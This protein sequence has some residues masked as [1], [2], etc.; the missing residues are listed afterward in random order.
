M[1]EILMP[2]RLLE[3][4]CLLS[5]L[6]HDQG[7]HIDISALFEISFIGIGNGPIK[8][9]LSV[10]G[11]GQISALNIG[12]ISIIFPRYIGKT[13][14]YR[15]FIEYRLSVSVRLRTDK[16]SVIGDRL[17]SNIGNRLSAKFNQYAIPAHD[18]L[19]Y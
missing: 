17:W 19:S 12:Y 13:P 11:F 16:I 5:P 6:A 4:S 1:I 9:R 10:I 2:P 15:Q 18:P 8:Y 14:I 3:S 7:W